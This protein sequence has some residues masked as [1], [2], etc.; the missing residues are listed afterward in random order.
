M[1]NHT[2]TCSIDPDNNEEPLNEE[3]QS[4]TLPT[5]DWKDWDSKSIGTDRQI[6]TLPIRSDTS[7][8]FFRNRILN[9]LH[10]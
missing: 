6:A 2:R 8:A 3:A 9:V 4:C 7:K 10:C 5:C 1:R